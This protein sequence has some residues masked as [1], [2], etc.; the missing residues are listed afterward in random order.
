M[1]KRYL[2]AC[3]ISVLYCQLLWGQQEPI[4]T[5]YRTNRF[6]INPAV[7][8]SDPDVPL[9]FHYR[10]QWRKFPGA[11]RTVNASLHFPL[12]DKHGF[13]GTAFHDRF[14]PNRRTGVQLAYAYHIPLGK[15]YTISMGL[16]G[17]IM[18]F[19]FIGDDVFFEDLNDPLLAEEVQG[20]VLGDFSVGIYFYSEELYFGISAPNLVQTRTDIAS[21]SDDASQLSRLYRHYFA[22]LGYHLRYD[23]FTLEPSILIRKVQQSAF[24]MEANVKLHSNKNPFF[25]GLSY[26]SD[27]MLSMM[28]GYQKNNFQ[29]IVSSDLMGAPAD[30][31]IGFG[32]S[33]ELTV[34]WNLAVPPRS[35]KR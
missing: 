6:L 21:Q 15:K 5:H 18:Q 35:K 30:Y 9:L 1:N 13:G 20:E 2:I 31:H 12:D 23:N 26:R 17:R 25:V 7:A 14:G 22:L 28:L 27:W 3:L 33:N 10:Y 24:Q 4:F 29:M 32:A 19:R 16:A 34:G 11:P 8:G